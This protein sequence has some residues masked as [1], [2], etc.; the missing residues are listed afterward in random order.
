MIRLPKFFASLLV[1]LLAM[2][3]PVRALEIGQ[4]LWGFDGHVVPDCFNPLSVLVSNPSDAPFDGALA[5]SSTQ[6]VA[7]T[8]RGV[9]YVQPVFLAPHTSR[10]V[11]FYV[12]TGNG[13]VHTGNGAGSYVL[14]WGRG[15]EENYELGG[16][17][18]DAPPA[19][20]WLRDTENPSAV[21]GSFNSFPEQL[22]PATAA[23]AEGLDAVVL[24]HVPRWEPVRREAF[25]D[26]VRL[27]GTVHLLP[28]TDGSLPVFGEGLAALDSREDETRVGLG[29]VAHHQI[30]PRE[31]DEKYLESHGFPPRTI[32]HAPPHSA[33]TINGYTVN[34]TSG[35]GPII[36][37]LEGSLFRKLSSLTRPKVS[38]P[39]IDFL[40][41]AYVAAIGPVHNYYRRRF[42]YRA[43][44]A[45]FLGCVAVF[46]TG[47]GM[48]GRRGYGESQTVHSLAVAR[49]LGGGRADVTQWISAFATKGDRYTLTHRAPANLYATDRWAQ[50]GGLIFNGQDGHLLLDIPLYSARA[51]LHRAIMTGDDTSVTV[52]QWEANDPALKTLRL[53]TTAGFP[54]HPVE[55][56]A[57]HDGSVYE[58]TLRDG[59]LERSD[60]P[61]ETLASYFSSG[62]LS[63]LA[64]GFHSNQND[65]DALRRLMPLL[66]AHALHAAGVFPVIVSPPAHGAD[67]QLLI[68]A[69]APASFQLQGRG[70]THENGWVLYVQDVFKP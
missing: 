67:L 45:I 41:L 9:E 64:I 30:P 17:D 48:A 23:A 5:L 7:A 1:L 52:E 8:E 32:D 38:W 55:I 65:P 56:R 34:T 35:N 50:A 54:Q 31:M 40:V 21:A 20:V 24:D 28:G 12:H 3:G 43:S 51:F 62:K 22:F 13:Y 6:G 53:R 25:L 61:A 36:Y 2:S 42:D 58:F 47:L 27:G 29:R 37:D 39:L 49:A 63:P 57:V 68:V 44:I 66:A 4:I 18:S 10:W 26:W 70:F 14:R 33:Q 59:V 11:Q 46:A 69:P 60:R 19:C 16:Q 15:A